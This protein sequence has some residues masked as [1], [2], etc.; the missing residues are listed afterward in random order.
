MSL[1][2]PRALP[3]ILLLFH[4]SYASERFSEQNPFQIK[5]PRVSHH[6]PAPESPLRAS[7][8]ITAQLKL[9]QDTVFT[10]Q[11]LQ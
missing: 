3:R 2:S 5:S 6:P 9:R 7:V 10:V 4:S 1:I 8:T 11:L